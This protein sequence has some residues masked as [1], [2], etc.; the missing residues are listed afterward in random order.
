MVNSAMSNLAG[1]WV[2]ATAALA[3][4]GLAGCC[5]TSQGDGTICGGSACA[6]FCGAG[7]QPVPDRYPVGSIVRAHCHTMEANGEAAD[8]IIHRMEFA[9]ETAALTPDG[10]DHLLEIAARIHS[11]PFPVIV[12]RSENNSNPQLDAERRQM[13]AMVL[14]DLG[15]HESDQ[16]TFVSPAYGRGQSSVEGEVD[17]YRFVLSR[18]GFGGANNGSWNNTGGIGGFGGF[19]SAGFGFGR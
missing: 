7:S 9:G 2:L 3:A 10:K 15:V 17:Y 8:F 6:L 1:K 14:S 4:I 12:E 11:V 5:H 19:G 18:G 16:R 13:I